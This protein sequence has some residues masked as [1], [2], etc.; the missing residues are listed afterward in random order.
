VLVQ[1]HPPPACRQ[2][3]KR[4]RKKKEPDQHSNTIELRSTNRV[5]PPSK[6][7]PPISI[8]GFDKVAWNA[9][10]AAS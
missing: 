9:G 8:L 5:L 4:K 2:N 3:R 6:G 7:D 1:L 10:R